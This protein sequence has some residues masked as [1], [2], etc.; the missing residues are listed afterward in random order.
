MPLLKNGI[1][2]VNQTILNILRTIANPVGE[3]NW[4]LKRKGQ[5]ELFYL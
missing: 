1:T 2:P 5:L 4:K 3:D